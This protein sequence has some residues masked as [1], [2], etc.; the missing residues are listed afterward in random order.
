M[1]FHILCLQNLHIYPDR[2]DVHLNGAVT[3]FPAVSIIQADIR[4]CS[5]IGSKSCHIHINCCLCNLCNHG[6]RTGN[7]DHILFRADIPDNVSVR[8]CTGS[9]CHKRKCSR[10]LFLDVQFDRINAS[11]DIINLITVFIYRQLYIGR[12]SGGQVIQIRHRDNIILGKRIRNRSRRQNGHRTDD[13]R[14]VEDL[15]YISR[16]RYGICIFQCYR[17][18]SETYR[19]N[20]IIDIGYQKPEHCSENQRRKLKSPVGC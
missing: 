10:F 14:I 16:I 15:I 1:Q 19:Y 8:E 18:I 3:D 11:A 13:I 7:P 12:I 17:H 2:L 20:R 5:D 6:L 9:G 4:I